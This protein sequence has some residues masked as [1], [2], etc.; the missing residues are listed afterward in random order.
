MTRSLSCPACPKAYLVR[1]SGH[2]SLLFGL[3]RC[4]QCL[5]VL[6]DPDAIANGKR[7]FAASH[8]ILVVRESAHHCRACGTRA[9]LGVSRCDGCS[10]ALGLVCPLCK[11]AMATLDVDGTVLDVCRGCQIAFFDKGEF[12]RAC[13]SHGAVRD[14]M[15][16][17][18]PGDSTGVVLD[19]VNY[20]DAV[21]LVVDVAGVAGQAA[22]SVAQELAPAASAAPAAVVEVGAAVLEVSES[23]LEVVGSSVG[24]VLELLGGVFDL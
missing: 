14:A 12:A 10:A 16:P 24:A 4:N 18:R 8:P 21:P 23:S 6:A 22:L 2:R 20:V 3:Y 19:A 5:G 17:W 9:K 7:L 15:R 1:L 11:L 13:D